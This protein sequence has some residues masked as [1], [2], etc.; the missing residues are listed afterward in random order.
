M[1]LWRHCA[2]GAAWVGRPAQCGPAAGLLLVCGL[3]AVCS[4]AAARGP[5]GDGGAL[6]YDASASPGGDGGAL[7]YDAS[8]SPGGGRVADAAG[9]MSSAALDAARVVVRRCLG[10][11]IT[12]AD[13]VAG[14][15]EARANR[16][17]LKIGGREFW[18]ALM[19]DLAKARSSIHVQIYGIDGD[20][21]GWQL[22]H[23]LADGARRGLRVRII[24]DRVGANL[25]VLH[26]AWAWLTGRQPAVE[27]LL[28]FCRKN[29]AEVVLHDRLTQALSAGSI[30]GLLDVY[31]FDH[32]KY[33]LIDGR[34]G[35]IGGFTMQADQLDQMYDAMVRVEGDV[36]WQL[37]SSFLAS[38]LANGGTIENESESQVI[39]RYFP[40]AAG[41]GRAAADI[42]MNVPNR[43]HSVSDTYRAEIRAARDYLYVMSPYISDNGI[44]ELLKD[45][46]RR[47]VKVCLVI[48]E[49]AENA[50]NSMNCQYHCQELIAAGVRV[51]EYV[52][53]RALGQLHGK[54]LVRDDEVAT[55]GSC[56]L[57]ALA[58]EYNFEAHVVSR[59]ARFV[60]DVRRRLF[61]DAFRVSRRM[62]RLEPGWEWLYVQ[63]AGRVL[64]LL[65]G[66]D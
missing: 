48:P 18:P 26:Y 65:D 43:Q 8:T 12:A 31:H 5:G 21:T 15:P 44:V 23:V 13:F 52:G 1:R 58:L 33:Y 4:V 39:S 66:I 37:Q 55:V 42:L 32:R 35:Y 49:R 3:L 63:A 38:F 25:S 16:L 60:Q 17:E 59:D 64:E 51:Y 9:G 29:G 54:A 62:Q 28:D 6:A 41:A 46:A 40:S 47:G 22:A 50:I 30:G 7:A 11:T 36:V 56:N 19:A 20:E 14:F 57:D 2:S 34:V 10:R 27:E 24:A 61:E 45:A 53:E